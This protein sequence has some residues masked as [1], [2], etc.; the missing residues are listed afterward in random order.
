VNKN[1]RLAPALRANERLENQNHSAQIQRAADWRRG[2]EEEK[3]KAAGRTRTESRDK[4]TTKTHT[5]ENRFWLRRRVRVPTE[6]PANEG[7]INTGSDL[8]TNSTH[9]LKY[10]FFI[11][12]QQGY[13]RSMKDTALPPSFDWKLKM[14]SWLTSTLG[15]MK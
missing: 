14:C 15:N 4:V 12:I 11:E 13:N 2:R 8:I 5:G 6:R 7:K 9:N 1:R 3:H 10:K